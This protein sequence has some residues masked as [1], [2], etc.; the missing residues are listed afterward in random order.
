MKIYLFIL[1]IVCSSCAVKWKGEKPNDNTQKT[2]TSKSALI[3][4]KSKK[5]IKPKNWADSYYEDTSFIVNNPIIKISYK[6]I[7]KICKGN[8]FNLVTAYQAKGPAPVKYKGD[9][10]TISTKSG[11]SKKVYISRGA[12]REFSLFLGKVKE[13]G[14]QIRKSIKQVELMYVYNKGTYLVKTIFST[15]FSDVTFIVK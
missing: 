14:A 11:F 1:L 12:C 2:T 10:I 8:E 3:P 9:Q 5:F 6:K 4:I 15:P 13:D 7:L